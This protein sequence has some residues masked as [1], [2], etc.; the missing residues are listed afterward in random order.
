MAAAA[1]LDDAARALGLLLTTEAVE[2]LVE[3]ESLLRERAI[4]LG[5]V[6]GSDEPRL[7]QR[8]IVDCLRAAAAV[9]P[10]D[11]VAFDVGSGAGLPG[12]V[13]AI[14]L[15]GLS[16]SLVEPRRSRIGFLELAVERLHLA[17]AKV[18]PGRAQELEASTG[19][20]CFARALAPSSTAWRL[21]A[22][23]LRPGGRLVYF[24][25]SDRWHEEDVLGPSTI[26]VRRTAV[27]E[28]AGPLVIMTR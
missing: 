16:V 28:S 23:V 26:E 2:R 3:F 15:P 1:D 8:H 4:P 14:A 11:R 12:V 18:V 10:S 25:G 7:R 9:E 21:V 27:L 5:L 20:V 19:D 22:P 17:N 13:V 24:A 6:S